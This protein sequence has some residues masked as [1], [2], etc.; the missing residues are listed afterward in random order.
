MTHPVA[1]VL[2]ATHPG[3]S[4]AVA[5]IVV[6]L[7]VGTGLEPWRV[8]VVGATILVSQFSVGLSNDWLDAERDRAV[9]RTD[10][11]VASGDLPEHAARAAAIVAAALSIALSALLGWPAAVAHLVFL[12]AGWS[13]NAWLKGTILS[14]LPYIVGFGSLP[15][16]VTLAR[17]EPALAS[18]WVITA[19]ALLGVA[20]HFSNVLPDLD[21]D[22][23]TGVQGLPH[24]IGPRV[25][26]VLI[27][28]SLSGASACV[29]LGLGAPSVLSLVGLALSIALAA[30]CAAL[31]ITRPASALVF[32]LIIAGALL[33][34]ILLATAGSRILL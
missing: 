8:V 9:G 13:Y 21:D 33:T 5:T 20:A 18:P 2:R 16:V 6:V 17:P 11:P 34:V 32:R 28:L 29:V 4:V 10:K 30:A 27:A 12:A 3:P 25:T 7:A 23:A 19:G 1:A 24:R 15:L 22:R 26:G 31:V 14:V